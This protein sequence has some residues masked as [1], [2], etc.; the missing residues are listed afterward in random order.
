MDLKNKVVIITGG[1]KGLGK[2]LALDL[3]KEGCKV[4]INSRSTKNL[5]N[6]AKE[7]GAVSI[8]GDITNEEQ[9]KNLAHE[10]I[11]KFGGIDIWINNAGIWLPHCN[12][13]EMD[14]K[15][16]HE[17]LEVNL[18]GTIYGSKYALIEMKKKGEGTIINILTTSAL[19][20]RAKSSGYGA[21][22]FAAMG[23]T[24]SLR[25][26]APQLKVISVFPG[27]MQTH[28]FDEKMPDNYGDFMNTSYVSKLI[29]ENLKKDDPEEEQIIKRPQV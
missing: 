19:E 2:Q 9:V 1:S 18:F 11:I 10:T 6:A 3:T 22:K 5:E 16:V 21:S 27:G 15:K 20:G 23:F 25:K 29:I 8:A 4:V 24:N 13:E 17:M 7:I 26:E 14:M 28:F 12:I